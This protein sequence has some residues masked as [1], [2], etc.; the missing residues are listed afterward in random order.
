MHDE[1]IYA[2]E[3]NGCIKCRVLSG[4]YILF[5]K[6]REIRF[7]WAPIQAKPNPFALRLI[8]YTIQAN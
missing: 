8:G 1:R 6:G 3:E 2:N 5:V 7:S 4:A